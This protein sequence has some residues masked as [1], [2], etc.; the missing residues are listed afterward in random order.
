QIED[1]L[2]AALTD[3]EDRGLSVYHRRGL[4][5]VSMEDALLYKSGSSKLDKNGIDAL[6]KIAGVMNDYPD[7]KVIVVGNTDDAKL[8]GSGDNWSLSTER[9]NGVV[10]ILRDTYNID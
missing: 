3:L 4:V 7:V 2:Q 9:A 10:R 8:K 6:S 5:F 1:K